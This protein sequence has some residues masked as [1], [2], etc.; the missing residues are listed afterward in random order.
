METKC[1][2]LDWGCVNSECKKRSI[3]RDNE[4]VSHHMRC[5]ID[6]HAVVREVDIENDNKNVDN[7]AQLIQIR[8]EYRYLYSHTLPDQ[9]FYAYCD[10]TNR[11]CKSLKVL[12]TFNKS[13]VIYYPWSQCVGCRF[14]FCHNCFNDKTVHTKLDVTCQRLSSLPDQRSVEDKRNEK[15]FFGDVVRLDDTKIRPSFTDVN[16][17]KAMEGQDVPRDDDDDKLENHNGVDEGGSDNE[18]T[19]TE[20][21]KDAVDKDNMKIKTLTDELTK[22]DK[23]AEEEKKK[24]QKKKED[25]ETKKKDEEM[26][27]KQEDDKKKKKDDKKKKGEETKQEEEKKKKEE[28]EEEKKKKGEEKRK[29]EE[30][31][32][33]G[34]EEEEKKKKKE[35]KEE[36]K[37]KKEEEK[38]KK[39]EK[40]EEKKGK[41]NKKK[42]EEKE[43][44]KGKKNKKKEEENEEEK[45]DNKEI[46]EIDDDDNN[47]SNVNQSKANN[48][49]DPPISLKNNA[50]LTKRKLHKINNDGNEQKEK[51]NKSLESTTPSPPPPPSS[52]YYE[53]SH[54]GIMYSISRR[55]DDKLPQSPLDT[56]QTDL[57]KEL[58]NM[59]FKN[60]VT[61]D[62]CDG[63][64]IYC[65][66]CSTIKIVKDTRDGVKCDPNALDP[67]YHMKCDTNFSR[68]PPD[69]KFT[70]FKLSGKNLIRHMIKDGMEFKCKDMWKYLVIHDY[71]TVYSSSRETITNGLSE[72]DKNDIRFTANGLLPILKEIVTRPWLSKEQSENVMVIVPKLFRWCNCPK[73]HP[74]MVPSVVVDQKKLCT[75]CTKK[76]KKK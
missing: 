39:E 50:I 62:S 2:C 26:K 7:K 54:K 51:K 24:K 55:D 40:K 70:S 65:M 68:L 11:L 60:L 57:P 56:F 15:Y 16:P 36:E 64:P 27:A 5:P 25:E 72:T 13:D 69:I 45:D 67:T 20:I 48:T 75:K 74:V 53:V 42:E 3:K 43:E 73:G 34:K 44:K 14:L 66:P 58:M 23:E 9:R 30:K 1:N 76:Q 38:K 10:Q 35:E 63:K 41:K 31:K 22:K 17:Y 61:D 12:L 8:N 29:K 47:L 71:L 28:K 19:E 46:M 32:K 6:G 18:I 52:S 33:K 4:V 59:H 49:K 21:D 37:K